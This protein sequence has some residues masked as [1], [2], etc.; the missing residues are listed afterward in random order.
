MWH[1]FDIPVHFTS[2]NLHYFIT[3]KVTQYLYNLLNSVLINCRE[4]KSRARLTA[5][6]PSRFDINFS[7]ER[8]APATRYRRQYDS[9]L[10]GF[11]KIRRDTR[12]WQLICRYIICEI[13][14]NCA[15]IKW[16]SQCQRWIKS[17]CGCD[18][19]FMWLRIYYTLIYAKY[20]ERVENGNGRSIIVCEILEMRRV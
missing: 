2:F 16:S 9:C 18:T 3:L 13:P 15:V 19:P 1:T 11:M 20:A 8:D 4:S 7:G 10:R 14:A 17:L 12:L 6:Q 5:K